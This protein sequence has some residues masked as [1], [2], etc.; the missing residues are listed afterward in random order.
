MSKVVIY[1][2]NVMFGDC[3]PAG[4]PDRIKAIPVPEEIK[5]KCL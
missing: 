5:S 1:E 2:F 4:N 3:D